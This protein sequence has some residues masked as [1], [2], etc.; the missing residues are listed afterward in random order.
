VLVAGQTHQVEFRY[1]RPDLN[2]YRGDRT[3]VVRIKRR[4]GQPATGVK[5]SI[6]YYDG[7][8]GTIPV[9]SGQV[10]KTGEIVLTGITDRL[11]KRPWLFGYVVRIG[12]DQRV[13]GCFQFQTNSD[14]ESFTFQLPLQIGDVA[15]DVDL[16]NVATGQHKRL[17]SL[18]GKFVC[19]DFWMTWCEY[20]QETIQKLDQARAE[21]RERWNDRVT[22]VPIAMDEE[23]ESVVG[24]LKERGWNHLDHYWAGPWMS[25][26]LDSA[27]ARAFCLDSAP[28]SFLIGPDGRILWQGHP[29]AKVSGMDLLDRIR[30]TLKVAQNSK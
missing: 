21:N 29:L 17:G 19:L 22:V 10:P 8:Y 13:L 6:G 7:H 27:P 20:C 15:P 9:F 16:V 2:A 28:R 1:V 26:P 12:K 11:P 30:E 23:P 4:D 25:Y 24:H 3:A 14:L 5:V 18:R